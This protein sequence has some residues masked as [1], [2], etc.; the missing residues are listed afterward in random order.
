MTL[1][2][3]RTAS[4]LAALQAAGFDGVMFCNENDRP[5]VFTSG[6]ETVAV[7]SKAA[8]EPASPTKRASPAQ[9]VL[10]PDMRSLAG[11]QRRIVSSTEQSKPRASQTYPRAIARISTWQSSCGRLHPW[12]A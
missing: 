3:E 1:V 12:S 6:P 2:R 7:G 10:R 4:D 9:C 5:Y 8:K 11:K